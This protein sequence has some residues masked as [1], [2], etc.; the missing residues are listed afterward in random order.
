MTVDMR[1]DEADGILAMVT[2]LSRGRAV[3][4]TDD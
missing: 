2:D 4:S 1:K 3:I